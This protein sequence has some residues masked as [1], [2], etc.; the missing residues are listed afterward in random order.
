MTTQTVYTEAAE[1]FAVVARKYCELIESRSTFDRSGFVSRVYALLPE[2]IAEAIR[3]PQVHFADDEN[4][5]QETR[6]EHFREKTKMTR[7]EWQELHRSL[8]EQLAGW[9]R[10]TKVFDPR[11]ETVAIDTSLADDLADI[12]QDLKNGLLLAE[13]PEVDRADVVFDWRLLFACHWG[14]HATSALCV[15]HLQMWEDDDKL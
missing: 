7:K 6:L 5:E 2:L 13:C 1:R 3:L 11:T 4:E 15:I 10:Y 8:E 9:D 14:R 12:Y